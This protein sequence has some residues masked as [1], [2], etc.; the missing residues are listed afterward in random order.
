MNTLLITGAAGV[1]GSELVRRYAEDPS[2]EIY[3]LSSNVKRFSED[4]FKSPNIHLASNEDLFTGKLPVDSVDCLIHG[5]F[6]RSANGTE[7]VSSITFT[8]KVFECAAGR[9]KKFVNI[10]SQGVYGGH[11]PCNSSEDGPV[12]PCDLYA[13]AKRACEEL[14]DVILDNSGTSLTHIRLA[15]LVGK[16]YMNHLLGKITRN[17]LENHLVKVAGGSQRFSFLH[18]DD[19]V[20]GIMAVAQGDA[21]YWQRIYNVGT[22]DGITL[23]EIAEAVAQTVSGKINK[24]I[25]VEFRESSDAHTIS[26]DVSRMHRDFN[27]YAQ[28][29]LTDAIAEIIGSLQS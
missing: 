3:A 27:W 8:R 9:V 19:A 21:K 5:A 17:A 28:K 7:L 11:S 13:M 12:N 18:L 4:F 29:T 16:R 24:R 10:S 20:S 6:A 22:D 2:V 25:P 15:S 23:A 26:L 1:L 14:G